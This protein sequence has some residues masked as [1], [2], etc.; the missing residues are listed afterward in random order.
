MMLRLG[1]AQLAPWGS[2]SLIRGFCGPSTPL[3]CS[4]NLRQDLAS[5]IY[6]VVGSSTFQ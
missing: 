1:L 4:E 2:G 5:L 3:G 6:Q